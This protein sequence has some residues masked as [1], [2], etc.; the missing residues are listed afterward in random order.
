[1][2]FRENGTVRVQSSTSVPTYYYELFKN[3]NDDDTEGTVF[4]SFE[5]SR[6]RKKVTDANGELR[7]FIVSNYNERTIIFREFT[8]YKYEDLTLCDEN[9]SF[10]FSQKK[11]NF[12]FNSLFLP[13]N[14]LEGND[15]V[16][17]TSS[18]IEGYEKL[19]DEER[20][21]ADAFMGFMWNSALKEIKLKSIIRSD[22]DGI[23]IVDGFETK[24]DRKFIF[25]LDSTV[26][27]QENK[28]DIERLS[29]AFEKLTSQTSL[30][31]FPKK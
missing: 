14:S 20:A 19:D 24:T 31:V 27:H 4:F 30:Q 23:V 12:I 1:V 5:E 7:N 22:F 26:I 15:V 17:R 28:S 21:K 11:I 18:E 8:L 3:S 2:L 13:L 25:E 9:I 6:F 10:Y 16:A 29:K